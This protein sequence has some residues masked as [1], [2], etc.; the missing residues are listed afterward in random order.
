MAAQQQSKGSETSTADGSPM[1][2]PMVVLLLSVGA[3]SAI[4]PEAST[5]EMAACSQPVIASTD[6]AVFLG[7]HLSRSNQEYP[8]ATSSLSLLSAR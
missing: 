7:A 8:C 2:W 4:P 6:R 1:L 3:C 5:A